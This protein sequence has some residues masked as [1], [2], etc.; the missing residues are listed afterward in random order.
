MRGEWKKGEGGARGGGEEGV[1]GFL[2]VRDGFFVGKEDGGVCFLGGERG[3]EEKKWEKQLAIQEEGEKNEQGEDGDEGKKEK[4]CSFILYPTLEI[5]LLVYESGKIGLWDSNS[6]SLLEVGEVDTE[7]RD[8]ME[9]TKEEVRKE[10]ELLVVF[11]FG[12]EI[13]P[14]FVFVSHLSFEIPNFFF[15]FFFFFF[16]FFQI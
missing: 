1:V 16:D 10:E 14:R 13:N 3:K 8:D 5:I 12:V 2:G 4:V 9:E 11:A 7:E 6:C 15:F